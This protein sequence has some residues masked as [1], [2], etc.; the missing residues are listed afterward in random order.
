[1][2]LPSG[3]RSRAPLAEVRRIQDIV[4][5]RYALSARFEQDDQGGTTR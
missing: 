4:L 1:V 2:R 5:L 3:P